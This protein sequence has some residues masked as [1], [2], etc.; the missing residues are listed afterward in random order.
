MSSKCHYSVN[1]TY[2]TVCVT[3]VSWKCHQFWPRYSQQSNSSLCDVY[4]YIKVALLLSVIIL[5]DHVTNVVMWYNLVFSRA[6]KYTATS[7]SKIKLWKWNLCFWSP[8]SVLWFT[9]TNDSYIMIHKLWRIDFK[10]EFWVIC[11]TKKASLASIREEKAKSQKRS[12]TG[13]FLFRTFRERAITDRRS[14]QPW[15]GSETY[16]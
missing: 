11:K 2:V 4:V 15:S 5:H 10:I 13:A 14:G 9:N 1:V 8:R 12:S 3:K 6:T 7:E 16:K